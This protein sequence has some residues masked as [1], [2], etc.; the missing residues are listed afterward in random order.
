M[1]NVKQLFLL[2]VSYT[3]YIMYFIYT[4]VRGV[5]YTSNKRSTRLCET[6]YLYLIVIATQLVQYD[7]W[8]SR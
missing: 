6:V 1:E 4:S 5:K 2:G 7:W 3:G 8:T